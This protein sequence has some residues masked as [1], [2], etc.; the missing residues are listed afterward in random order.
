[1]AYGNEPGGEN[2]SAYL[3]KWVAHF[4]AA[5][6]RRFYTS[7]AGWPVLPESDFHNVPEPRI[8]IWFQGLSSRVNAF[9]PETAMDYT[10]FNEKHYHGTPVVSHESGEWCAYPNF[11]EIPKYTGHL[12]PKNFEIFRETLD[13]HHMADQARAFVTASGRH[14]V[15][16]Y[17]EEIESALRTTNMSGFQLLGLQDYS[18]QGP[19]P[20]GVLDAFWEPKG[21]VTAQ[22]Y[23]RFCNVTVPLARL[24][25]RVFTTDEKLSVAVEVAHF[26]QAPLA[27]APISWR[28][29]SE[30]SQ[31]VAQ[32]TLPSV[33]IPVNNGT[34]LGVI[35]IDLETFPAPRRYRLVVSLDAGRIEN[36]W[37]IWIYPKTP[38]SPVPSGILV[39]RQLDH[40]A[41]SALA[42]GGSV[43]WLIPPGTVANDPNHPIVFGFSPIFWSTAWTKMQPPTT[44]GI[45]CDPQ[46]PALAQFPTDSHSNWHWWYPIQKAQPMILDGLPPA[47]RPIVQVIDDW[48]TNRRLGLVFEAR[49]GK[50][51]LLVS[52]IDFDQP[53]D[54][55]TAQLRH[56]LLAYMASDAFQPVVE[57]THEQLRSLTLIQPNLRH[58]PSCNPSS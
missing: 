30:S 12:K 57:L 26:G 37:D 39:T 2:Q 10:A 7:A 17:K 3:S 41:L 54:P 6:P 14:Q 55:V 53:S 48:F 25:K 58:K 27:A 5:D 42:A 28:L 24:P 1:M 15:L 43:A 16:T 36:D 44:L 47:L 33:A 52:S 20:V 46:A 50:G 32:G 13:Q 4:K 29:V 56:S 35:S 18:G 22:E 49:L 19:A 9:P 8:Q 40:Q 11:D 38:L 51:K 31:V 45:L 34:Q 23:R 21:Y